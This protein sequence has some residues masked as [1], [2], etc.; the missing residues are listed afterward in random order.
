MQKLTLTP[1]GGLSNR[2]YAIA[3][4]IGFCKD[5]NIQLKIIWFKDWG[6]GADFHRILTLNPEIKHVEIVDAQWYHWLYSKPRKGNLWIPGIWQW[7][8]FNLKVNDFKT[9]FTLRKLTENIH[10]CNN[11]HLISYRLFYEWDGMF[12]CLRPINAIQNQIDR[13]AKAF[14]DKQVI[15]VHIRRS[16]HIK[17]TIEAPTHLFIQRMKQEIIANPSTVFYLASD[18]MEEKQTLKEIFGSKIATSSQKVERNS[19]QGIVNAVIELYVLA[20]TQKIYG[21]SGSTYSALA[22]KIGKKPIEV[23]TILKKE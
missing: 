2:I 20:S 16:D 9:K 21:S 11:I 10:T 13:Q 6:M 7:L 19:E 17:S 18:S 1:F 4:A 5:N 14:S 3:S 22:A 8:A 23:L 15:G 12:D